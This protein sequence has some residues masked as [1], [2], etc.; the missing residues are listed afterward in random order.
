MNPTITKIIFVHGA[1]SSSRVF[2]FIRLSLKDVAVFDDF[3]Y[4]WEQPT[5]L[6]AK[7]LAARIN[8]CT[9]PVVV[10]GHSLGGNVA[11]LATQ[12]VIGT[13]LKQI[14]TISSPFGGSNAATMIKLM[15]PSV[16]VLRHIC[17]SSP[18]IAALR[19]FTPNVPVCSIVTNKR[20]GLFQYEPSD[21]V[22]TAQSQMAL[23]YP[24]YVKLDCGH[25]EVLLMPETVDT[26][27][28]LLHSISK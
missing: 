5:D 16:R 26:I 10:V 1:F 24:N 20:L 17:S 4:D 7:Q 2:N 14:V 18:H 12:H 25:T 23:P 3:E 21:G 27:R 11:V 22:V 19:Q 8:D 13:N 9:Q 6:V 15:Y 28:R